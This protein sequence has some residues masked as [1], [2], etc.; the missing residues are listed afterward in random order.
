MQSKQSLMAA[1]LGIAM[2][3]AMAIAAAGQVIPVGHHYGWRNHANDYPGLICDED[4]DDCH[5][6]LESDEEDDDCDAVGG[7]EDQ[8][9]VP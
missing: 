2:V 7:Y 6:L 5:S 4:G 9:Y 3:I 8:Y 1:L